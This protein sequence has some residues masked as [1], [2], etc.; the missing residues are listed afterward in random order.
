LTFAA[1][2]M[3]FS[4]ELSDKCDPA[5]D[6]APSRQRHSA[7]ATARAAAAGVTRSGLAVVGRWP[8]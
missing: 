2:Q 1:Q 3:P 8:L 5:F 6:Q 4:L 7:R